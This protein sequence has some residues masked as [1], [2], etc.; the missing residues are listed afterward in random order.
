M[1]WSLPSP[2]ST[3]C[4]CTADVYPF[5]ALSVQFMQ[6][7]HKSLIRA[8]DWLFSGQWKGRNSSKKDPVIAYSCEYMAQLR[9]R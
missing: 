4:S 6:T 5:F 2:V 7:I 1:L 9:S 3:W 8:L